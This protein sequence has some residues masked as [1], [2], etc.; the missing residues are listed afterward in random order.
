MRSEAL[1]VVTTKVTFSCDVTPHSLQSAPHSS[2]E[3][4]SSAYVSE[5]SVH[6]TVPHNVASK[7]TNFLG[8]FK[9]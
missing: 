6:F 2:E 4:L 7:K 5:A 9:A 8:K 1:T 3:P